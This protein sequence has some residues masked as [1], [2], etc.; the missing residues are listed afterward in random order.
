MSARQPAPRWLMRLCYSL[1]ATALV[2]GL[3]CCVLL[4]RSRAA[5]SAPPPSEPAPSAGFSDST[6][7][8]AEAEPEPDPASEEAAQEQRVFETL[9]SALLYQIQDGQLTYNVTHT[10]SVENATVTDLTGFQLSSL[11]ELEQLLEDPVW[12][13]IADLILDD[14]GRVT[15]ICLTGRSTRP[16]IGLS[17]SSDDQDYESY[18]EVLRRNGAAPVELPQIT[19]AASAQEALSQVSGIMVTGGED[20]DPALYGDEITRNGSNDINS[21][22][23]TSDY[24]LI[25]QAITLDVPM[26]ALCR[27]CQMLNVTQG[28]A[29]IQDITTYLEDNDLPLPQE[30]GVYHKNDGTQY[31][32]INRID[33][34]AKW[35]CDIVGG[36]QYPNAATFHHQAIDPDRVGQGL[37][38]VAWTDDGMIEAVEYQANRF[39][40]GVQFHPER[41]ALRDTLDIDVDQD[42]CNRFFQALVAAASHS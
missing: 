17:W 16:T 25:Q 19:D 18:K 33:P 41:D 24:H 3:A 31:H 15:A 35:L 42:A 36:T 11:D 2:L 29:L 37:T 9:S 14:Q 7:S 5:S 12:A 1:T 21:L 13:L 10:I 4:F 38:P 32:D 27:G 39:A 23:D 8:K 40:L 22:R 28:G 26:L 6:P 34:D 20:I 30:T